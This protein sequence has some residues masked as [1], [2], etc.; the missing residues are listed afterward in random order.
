MKKGL[1]ILVCLTLAAAMLAS[2]GSS[3]S[4]PAEQTLEEPADQS[5]PA[6]SDNIP[7]DTGDGI[8]PNTDENSPATEVEKWET[9]TTD[10][11]HIDIPAAWSWAYTDDHPGDI[12]IFSDDG[13]INIFVGYLIAGDPEIYL[14]ENPWQPFIFSNGTVGYMLVSD[15]SI[16]WLNPEMFLGSGVC[17]F[18]D[19][20]VSDFYD[21]EEVIT[22]IAETYRSNP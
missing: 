9:I 5:T 16:M 4:A 7:S 1:L 8:P 11:M 20:G 13:L 18:F 22:R 10:W 12:D 6:P 21:N 14:E 17:F 19:G 15:E 3:S 2:C